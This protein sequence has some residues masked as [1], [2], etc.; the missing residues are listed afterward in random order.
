[1]QTRAIFVVRRGDHP[2]RDRLGAAGLAAGAVANLDDPGR[3][4]G[5]VV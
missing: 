2:D 4:G 1:M 5:D 3:P